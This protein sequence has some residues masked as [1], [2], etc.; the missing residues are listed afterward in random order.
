MN[1]IT[2]RVNET[3]KDSLIKLNLFGHYESYSENPKTVKEM[4][5]LAD[6]IIIRYYFHN[7]YDK[8][9]KT[10]NSIYI[11]NNFAPIL[12]YV[13]IDSI[14][15]QKDSNKVLYLKSRFIY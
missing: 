10:I 15:A 4:E 1:L 8:L 3:S 9:S 2:F 6:T 12:E 14:I 13:K 11:Q 5:Y 7:R